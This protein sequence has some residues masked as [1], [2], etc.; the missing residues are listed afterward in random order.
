M[1]PCTDWFLAFTKLANGNV[2]VNSALLPINLLSQILLLPVY[3]YVF[4]KRS[5][6]IPFD[7][8]F[9]V[10]INWVL[11]PFVLA[12]ILRFII[13]K[14]GKH[15]LVRSDMLAEWGMLISL[16][17]LVFSIFNTNIDSLI[18]EA[19]LIPVIFSAILVFFV[20]T[21]FLIKIIS[22]KLGLSKEE[23]VS[24]TM[25]TLARNAPL[26]LAISIGL[27]PNE[28]A[29]QLV[30]ILGMLI[31]LPHLVAVTYFLKK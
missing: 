27:F 11:V 25:T 30:L 29:I 2:Q 7:S 17:F 10:L 28:T 24:L 3:L 6:S 1:A 16:I 18:A 9:D 23:K 31:E 8:F 12:Q 21:Y 15:V 14:T 5:I 22:R 13:T 4:T 19:Y 26:M 20:V